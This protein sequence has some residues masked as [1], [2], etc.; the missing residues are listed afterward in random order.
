MN[1]HILR[2]H[3]LENIISRL[4]EPPKTRPHFRLIEEMDS[5][6]LVS[7][8][9]PNNVEIAFKDDFWVNA[10]HDELNQ[11]ERNQDW[12]LVP[13][14]TNGSIIGTKWIFRNKTNEEEK[15]HKK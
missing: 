15:N 12:H 4:H 2:N 6:A 10:M 1:I 13:R 11:F 5:L 8:L 7:Q 9:E 3:P 14:P